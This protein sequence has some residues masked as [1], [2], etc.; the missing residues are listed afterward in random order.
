[1]AISSLLRKQVL[2]RSNYY[3]EYCK[4]SSRI[5][6]MPLIVEHVY[7]KSLGG[8]DHESNLAAACYRCNEFKGVKTHGIDPASGYIV[9]LFH[10]RIQVWDEHFTWV[11]GGVSVAGLSDRGRATVIALR[12]NN[13]DVVSARMLW[14]LAG[15]HPP[16]V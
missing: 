13:E 11:N 15:W 1:M 5:T 10:P 14:V 9:E 6:G 16:S 3:C 12:L 8:K 2:S 7:P 4:T